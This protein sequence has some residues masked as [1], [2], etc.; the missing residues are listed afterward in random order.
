[1]KKDVSKEEIKSKRLKRCVKRERKGTQRSRRTIVSS[2]Q[3]EME[4]T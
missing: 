3:P 1:M 2:Q 4:E